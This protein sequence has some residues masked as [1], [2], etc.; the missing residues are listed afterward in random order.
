MKKG[1]LIAAVVSLVL[2]AWV[3][4]HVGLSAMFVQLK[5][6]RVAVPV[7]LALSLLRCFCKALRGP[8]L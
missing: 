2:F 5:A 7:V 3:I 8:G 6:M 4:G 1:H